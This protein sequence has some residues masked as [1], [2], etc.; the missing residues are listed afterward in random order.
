MS[1]LFCSIQNAPV[2]L[3]HMPIIMGFLFLFFW[4]C[5]AFLPLKV[6]QDHLVIS[7][8]HPRVSYFSKEPYYW[9]RV[10]ETE[11]WVPSGLGYCHFSFS[12]LNLA[13]RAKPV[14]S[15][16]SKKYLKISLHWPV[17]HP[18]WA[19]QTVVI[20]L[21]DLVLFL[22]LSLSWGCPYAQTLTQLCSHT[23]SSWLLVRTQWEGLEWMILAPRVLCGCCSKAVNLTWEKNLMEETRDELCRQEA[24]PQLLR[25]RVAGA[26]T[27][28]EEDGV[29]LAPAGWEG[30]G[31]L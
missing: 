7:C 29:V 30:M 1:D 13:T 25:E 19:L 31:V 15:S 26:G 27:W 5:L 20:H 21:M 28:G 16:D 9:G 18:H 23:L 6:H 2:S 10:L 17:L 14:S 11:V 24:Q 8:P 12:V 3:W 4:A 22:N